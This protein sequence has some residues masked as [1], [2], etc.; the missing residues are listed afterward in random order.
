MLLRLSENELNLVSILLLTL[1][2]YPPPQQ[3]VF[4][5]LL[6]LSENAVA[7]VGGFGGGGGGGCGTG[8][9]GEEVLNVVEVVATSVHATQGPLFVGVANVLLMCC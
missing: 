9:A 1:C 3:A 4:D 8:G 6:R 5:M 2:K 7:S